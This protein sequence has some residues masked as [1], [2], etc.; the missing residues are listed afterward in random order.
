MGTEA[1]LDTAQGRVPHRRRRAGLV[2]LCRTPVWTTLCHHSCLRL[3]A[4]RALCLATRTFPLV[5]MN[6]RRT[7][8]AEAPCTLYDK[9]DLGIENTHTVDPHTAPSVAPRK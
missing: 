1:R 8:L 9:Y 4:L 2:H 3:R 7:R 5:L 6:H